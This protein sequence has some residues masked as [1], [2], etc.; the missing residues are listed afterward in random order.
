M[1]LE[2]FILSDS[3]NKSFSFINIV[4]KLRFLFFF[5]QK[6]AIAA[7]GPTIILLETD[8]IFATYLASIY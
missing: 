4:I 3:L 7:A 5:F 2:L 1:K 6:T 8:W